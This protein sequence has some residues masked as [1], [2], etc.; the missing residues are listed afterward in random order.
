M[1]EIRTL[2]VY[3]GSSPGARPAY[4]E[5][6]R[7]L[8]AVLAREGIGLVTGGGRVGL[9]GVIADA[10]LEAGGEAVGVIPQALLDREV[11]HTG[12][13]DLVVVETMHQRKA[14][15]ASRADAVVALPGGLGTLEEITEML[16]WSQL[17]LHA[18]PCG[19]L[20]VAGYYD[21]LVAFLDHAVVER[22]VRTS[23]RAMLTVASSPEELLAGLRAHL[24]P[25]GG[26]GSDRDDG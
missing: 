24:P 22:F 5:A 1:T 19:L 26:N 20:N 15:M 13:T 16:T 11:G 2:C 8:G 14:L 4:A 12:L 6:A 9:M 23:H 7:Q 3:C 21:A 18:K 17:G 10:V 25:V